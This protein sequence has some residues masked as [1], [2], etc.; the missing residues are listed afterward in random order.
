[1]AHAVLHATKSVGRIASMVEEMDHTGKVFNGHRLP[2]YV[3]DLVVC[4]IRICNTAPGGRID[5]YT[6]LVE[7][8]ESKNNVNLLDIINKQ[9]SP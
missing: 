8:I 5:L 7:R 9:H 3:A 2:D 6:A 1:M 4:A